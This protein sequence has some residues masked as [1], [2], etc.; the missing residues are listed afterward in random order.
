MPSF[1]FSLDPVPPFSLDLTASALRRRPDNITDLFDQGT[2][3]RVLVVGQ[4][5]VEVSLSQEGTLGEDRVKVRVQ[6]STKTARPYIA[7]IVVRMFGMRLDLSGF[8]TLAGQDPDLSRLAGKFPGLKPPRFPTA[9][10]A[11]V[12]G[13]ACQQ[14][15]LNVGILILNRLSRACAPSLETSTGLRH[16]FPRPQDCLKL[17]VADLRE[18]GF[19]TKKAGFLLGLANA[20][21]A[22]EL[23]LEGLAALKRQE[24]IERLTRLKGIGRWTAEY[25]LLRGFGD[26]SGFPGDD[27]GGR[28]K[29]RTWLGIDRP[30]SYEDV[31]QVTLKW[32]PYSGLVYFYL[33]LDGLSQRGYIP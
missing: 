11:A 3:S 5:P 30:L 24:A 10:E 8:Y 4:T 7:A 17:S 9:F 12:N 27:V 29:L 18:L 6:G 1:T 16:A 32:R 28:N 33:L 21:V 13:I 19:S 20:I 2:Y 26:L 25:I 31:E 22:G 15:S 23:D 14:L